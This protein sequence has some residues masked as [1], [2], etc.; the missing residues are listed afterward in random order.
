MLSDR[1]YSTSGQVTALRLPKKRLTVLPR[2]DGQPFA[3]SNVFRQQDQGGDSDQERRASLD[4]EQDSPRF[5][6]IAL[7]VGNTIRDDTVEESSNC[8]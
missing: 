2:L 8:K 3:R 5:E 1:W 4:Q 7:D 6:T